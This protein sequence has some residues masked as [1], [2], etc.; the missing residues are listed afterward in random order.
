MKNKKGFTLVELILVLS[1]T[2]ILLGVIIS[3]FLQSITYYKIDETKAANQDSLN[4]VATSIEGKIRNASLVTATGSGC[5][6][7]TSAGAYTYALNTTTHALSVNTAVLT[8]RIA[9]F[10]CT[11]SV[12]AKTVTLSITTVNDS[13]GDHLSLNTTIVIRKGD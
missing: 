3:I 13:T 8:E 9:S 4:L 12:D 7:T 2:S 5:I 6:V 10:T 1:V 11:P